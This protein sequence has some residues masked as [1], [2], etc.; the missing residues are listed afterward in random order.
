MT[1]ALSSFRKIS[2]VEPLLRALRDENKE[3]RWSVV[4]DLSYL[5]GEN[6]KA[7]RIIRAALGNVEDDI[8]KE[9]T[10][11]LEIMEEEKEREALNAEIWET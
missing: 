1:G 4:E 8:Q 2:A 11:V 10:H 3:V 9:A 6:K 7:E 5:G